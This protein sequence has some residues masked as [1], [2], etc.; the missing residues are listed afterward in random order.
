MTIFV[1][2]ASSVI[3]IPLP[4]APVSSPL[5][6]TLFATHTAPTD[7]KSSFRVVLWVYPSHRSTLAALGPRFGLA[8]AVA[9]DC[10]ARLSYARA[11]HTQPASAVPCLMPRGLD[12]LQAFKLDVVLGRCQS[13]LNRLIIAH[14]ANAWESFESRHKC[15][16]P[17][18]HGRISPAV[19]IFSVFFPRMTHRRASAVISSRGHRYTLR[20]GEHCLHAAG[21][22][23]SLL[24]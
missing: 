7:L 15:G 4:S 11:W 24:L 1:S 18:C 5:L 13:H 19:S 8:A 6:L 23:G 10:C 2:S 3:D 9:A 12:D 20:K 14:L 17:S 22:R 16:L 21:K